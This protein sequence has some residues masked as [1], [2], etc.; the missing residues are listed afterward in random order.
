MTTEPNF[1]EVLGIAANADIDTVKRAYRE[2]MRRYHPDAFV[3]LMAKA[4]Q[5]GDL[6]QIRLLEKQIEESKQ[7][8]KQ[9]NIAYEILSDAAKRQAYDMR[10]EG[11]PQSRSAP[12]YPE[13][14]PYRSGPYAARDAANPTR[15]QAP[16]H[17]PA[18]RKP[19]DSFPFVLFGILAG[20]LFLAFA[21]LF[22]FGNLP[23]PEDGIP[24]AN[25]GR[26]S[27]QDLQ[28]TT[29]A[30]QVTRVYMTRIAQQPTST[31]RT[32]EQE[33]LTGDTFAERGE[34]A[35]AAELYTN[36]I[37]RGYDEVEVYFKRAQAYLQMG[38]DASLSLA[39]ADLTYVIQQQPDNAA[40]YLER[41]LLQYALWQKNGASVLVDAIRADATRYS[42]LGGVRDERLETALGGLP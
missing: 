10:R 1:Y 26:I 27:A 13:S 20:G 15:R 12:Y 42:E 7:K 22:A 34:Y 21:S 16:R 8:T 41:A 39:F 37:N 31:P 38:T 17:A 29:S 5:S 14:D 24:F 40:A 3:G 33:V 18:P 9:L 23:A 11:V 19:D 2:Q 4:R 30:Q 28:A 35:L 32:L 6:R 25:D 36:A